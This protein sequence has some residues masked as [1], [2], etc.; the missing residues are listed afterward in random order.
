MNLIG[1]ESTRPEQFIAFMAN[2]NISSPGYDEH[3]KALM[4]TADLLV[5]AVRLPPLKARTMSKRRL[6]QKNAAEVK[7]ITHGIHLKEGL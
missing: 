4:R 3:E 5:A 7:P 2:P 6:A 1:T